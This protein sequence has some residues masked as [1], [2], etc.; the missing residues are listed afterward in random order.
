MCESHKSSGFSGRQRVYWRGN[1]Q[2]AYDN[3]PD[4]EGETIMAYSKILLQD[5]LH[6][7]DI[8]AIHYTEYTRDFVLPGESHDFWK[9]QCVDKGEVEILAD[10]ESFLIKKGQIIFHGPNEFHTLKSTGK[11][12][13]N[14]MEMSFSC[15]SPGMRLFDKKVF[16]L[17]PHELTL[18]GL[19][20]AEAHRCILT[21]MHDP[22]VTAME[23]RSDSLFGSQQLVRLYLEQFLIQLYRRCFLG[24]ADSL[25]DFFPDETCS[26]MFQKILEYLEDNIRRCMSVDDICEDNLIEKS[27]LQKIFRDQQHCGVIDYFS[28]M[29]IDFAKDLIQENSM[30]ISEISNYLGYSSIH[31]F[32]RQFKKI[33]G[34][35]PSEYTSTIKGISEWKGVHPGSRRKHD[36]EPEMKPEFHRRSI[37]TMGKRSD[38]EKHSE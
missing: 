22:G 6:V 24:E 28:R 37:P 33:T 17:C 18:L 3:A 29:K 38:W 35:S 15:S 11:S 14:L 23:V 25:Q 2:P 9:F 31:Y 20:M 16:T 10:E 26:A 7:D 27:Q 34:M 8:F 30:N 13:P 1:P 32:S 19:L 5:D 4:G 21:P 12:G 36:S